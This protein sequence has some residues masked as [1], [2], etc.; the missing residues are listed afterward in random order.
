M[1]IIDTNIVLSWVIQQD[2]P[3]IDFIEHS[4]CIAPQF[5]K[6]ETINILRKYYVMKKIP[7]HIIEQYYED[8]LIV[9]DIFVPD[10]TILDRAKSISF[11]I[12]H[13]IYDCLFI[14][15]AQQFE[16]PLLSFDKRLLE[17]AD[18]LGVETIKI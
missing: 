13:P 8:I 1:I 18:S 3:E 4:Q 7:L 10:E 2:V 16:S 6:I 5:L 9:I 11:A 15:L 12:N 14:A 17:K